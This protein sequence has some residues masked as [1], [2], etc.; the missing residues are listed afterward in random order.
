MRRILMYIIVGFAS[1]LVA[2]RVIDEIRVIIF[3]S[4]GNVLITTSDIRPGLDGRVR[5]LRQVIIETLMVLDAIKLT[6]NIS[7]DDVERFLAQLQQEQGY[8]RVELIQFFKE[9]GFSY[10][11]GREQLKRKQMVDAIIDYRVRSNKQMVVTQQAVE[12]YF[13][14]HPEY[15]EATYTLA[16][17]FI[18]IDN[19]SKE[20]ARRHYDAGTL[21]PMVVW[22]DSFTIKESELPDDKKFIIDREKGSV[23]SFDEA[24]DGVELT[25]LVAKKPVMLIPMQERYAAIE[26]TLK[27]QRFD[28]L[29]HDYE[30]ELLQKALMRFTYPADEKLIRK[31]IT[32]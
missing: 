29:L 8:S 3:T 5:D 21:A 16:Q 28:K 17:A 2:Y 24:D 4:Q 13:Q 10:E 11:E 12:E 7:D 25:R 31:N 23:V 6:I 18:S 1:S 32:Q 19:M 26:R 9:L 27:V 30:E 14:E 15:E 22:E 20:E